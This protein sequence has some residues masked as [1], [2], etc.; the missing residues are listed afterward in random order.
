LLALDWRVDARAYPDW[1]VS[2][3]GLRQLLLTGLED[4]TQFGKRFERYTFTSEGRVQAQFADGSCAVGDVLVGAMGS[5]PPCAG[6]FYQL[7]GRVTCT[8]RQSVPRTR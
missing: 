8:S 3:A 2:R 1:R 6:N 7:A 4:V 5:P